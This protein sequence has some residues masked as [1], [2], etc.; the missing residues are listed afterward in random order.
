MSPVEIGVAVCLLAIIGALCAIRWR[1][2][3]RHRKNHPAIQLEEETT[4]AI[5]ADVYG[6][7]ELGLAAN[8]VGSERQPSPAPTAASSAEGELDLQLLQFLSDEMPGGLSRQIDRYLAAFDS[9]RG[10]ARTIF[11]TSDR[12]QIHRLAHRLIAHAGAVH[13]IPLHTLAT[14]MQS[15]AA[16][17]Q[18]AELEQLMTEFDREFVILR[19]KLDALRASTEHA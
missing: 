4:A 14:I 5:P 13:C 1:L 16:L 11:A 9:D 18:P 3:I 7:L 2:T 15:N 17:L 10:G 19:K 8:H 12:Q 6:D